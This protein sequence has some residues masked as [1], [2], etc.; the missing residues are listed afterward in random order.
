[1][2]IKLTHK[3]FHVRVQALK[4]FRVGGTNAM[5]IS[6]LLGLSLCDE[7]TSQG[8]KNWWYNIAKMHNIGILSKKFYPEKC[9]CR[10]ERYQQG[11]NLNWRHRRKT[12][13]T[14][15]PAEVNKFL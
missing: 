15:R 11:L 7:Y 10:F 3:F 5:L 9:I 4:M 1:M 13:L 12:F 8:L 2:R 14:L 6:S